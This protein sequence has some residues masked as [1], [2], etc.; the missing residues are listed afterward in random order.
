MTVEGE[1]RAWQP[2][3]RI[4]VH[5]WIPRG[6]HV[7]AH[8][9]GGEIRLE[10]IDGR[11]GVDSSGGLIQ[12]DGASGP[13]LAS[14]AGGAIRLRRIKSDVRAR[15]AGGLIDVRRVAGQLDARTLG[16]PIRL[17]EVSGRVDAQTGAG[18]ISAVLGEHARGSLRTAAGP[19]DLRLP[20]E[21]SLELDARAAGAGVRIDRELSFAGARRRGPWL[22]G[23]IGAGGAT[24]ELRAATGGIQVRAR[25]Q[26]QAKDR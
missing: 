6:F 19:I 15:S 26:H 14:T 18:S 25:E 5:V 8:T 24:L 4:R 7:D 9:G 16:G 21:A 1:L 3:M 11:C 23:A 13:V 2:G 20:G 22:R 10:R 17:R 12:I